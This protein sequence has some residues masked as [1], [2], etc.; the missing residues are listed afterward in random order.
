MAMSLADQL[1]QH[2]ASVFIDDTHE[3]TA[4]AVLAWTVAHEL[5]GPPS[6]RESLYLEQALVAATFG[7][8][9]S[10]AEAGEREY[11][12]AAQ[13]TA[14]FLYFDDCPSAAGE[15]AAVAQWLHALEQLGAGRSALADFRASFADYRASLADE[16]CMHAAALTREQFLQLR[17]RTIFVEPYLDHWRVLAGIDLR[18]GQELARE[19]ILYANDLGSLARDTSVEQSEMNLIVLDAARLGSLDAAIAAAVA[20]YNELLNQLGA[21]VATLARSSKR[22]EQALARLLVRV[23]DGNLATMRLLTRRYAQS[24]PLL[25]Q[26]AR[27][28]N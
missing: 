11:L 1:R 25:D 18:A 17:R 4:Q 23:V 3:R 10:A 20:H 22:S 13:F 26:L 19:A 2:F 27:L 14:I 24:A 21:V 6:E 8:L 16:R 7:Y 12:C 5:F 9:C 28:G 15:H